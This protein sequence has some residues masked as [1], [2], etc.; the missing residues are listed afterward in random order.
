MFLREM[1]LVPCTCAV[2]TETYHQFKRLQD[3]EIILLSI[4]DPKYEIMQH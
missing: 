4:I 1:I 3:V 2:A